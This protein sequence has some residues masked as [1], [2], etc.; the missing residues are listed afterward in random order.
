MIS[1]SLALNPAG[2]VADVVIEELQFKAYVVISEP[3]INLVADFVP[4]EQFDADGDVH[5][6]AVTD[7]A[8]ARGQ[9]EDLVFNMNMGD[10]AVFLC[11]DLPAY[12]ATLEELAAA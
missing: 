4:P 11:A 3:D 5:V 10:A 12:E 2:V 7:S 1:H 8:Q 9:V 6:T